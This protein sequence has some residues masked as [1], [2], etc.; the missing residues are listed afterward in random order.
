LKK[1][2]GLL[3]IAGLISLPLWSQTDG[4][5]E[6]E[7]EA[8]P[9]STKQIKALLPQQN[10]SVI[11][12][13]GED[14]VS[15]N[16][17]R[18]PI[19]NYSCSGYRTLQLNQVNPLHEGTSY[20]SDYVFYVEEDGIYELWYGGTPPGEKDELLPS[21]AS[22][23]RYILDGIYIEDIYRENVNVVEEYAPAY[24]WNY[25][26]NVTLS[27]GE[28]SLK[29]EIMQ[30]RSYDSRYFFYLD[31]FFLVKQEE[32]KRV[33]SGNLPEVFPKD[34]DNR[35]IDSS[36]LS[37]EEYDVLIRDNPENFENYV[38]VSK[39]YSLIGDYLNAL[40]Y[41]KKASYLEP[42]NP[43]IMLLTAKNMIW[44]GA[45]S[46]G[47]DLYKS[48]L[49]IVPERIDLWTEAGKIAGW[50]GQY[51]DSI[52]FFKG[53]LKNLPNDLSLMANLG[54][55]NLW[56]G[57]LNEAEKQFDKIALLTGD[58]L[59]L[60]RDLAEIFRTNGYADKAVPL[61]INMMKKYPQVLQLYMDLEQTYIENGQ[62]EKIPKLRELTEKTFIPDPEYNKIV[63][64]FYETQSLKEKV[65]SDY[66][67]QLRSDP[68]NLILRRTLAEIYFWNGYK[69]KAIAEYRNILSNYTYLNLLQT[70]IDM[71]SYLEL[72]D[73]NYALSNFI[74]SI[75]QYINTNQKD[76]ISDLKIYNKA[77]SDLE[78]MK[79]K[80]EAAAAKG[81]PVDSAAEEN[82]NNALI[83]IE[84]VLASAIYKNESFIEKYNSISTQFSA[85]TENLKRLLEDEIQSKESFKQLLDGVDWKWNREAM[86]EELSLVKDD[87]VLL[88]HFVLG[89]IAQ[90]EGRLKEAQVNFVTV[91]GTEKPLKGAPFA[92]YETEVWLG[93]NA[94]GSDTYEKYE[95]EIDQYCSYIYFLNDYLDYLNP[96]EDE[97]TF[98]Y[99][100]EDASISVNAILEQFKRIKGDS[101]VIHRE[102]NQ[103]INSIRE[104]LL[105]NMEQGFYRLSSDTYL[106][107]NELGDFY[108]NEKM[109]PEAISQYEQVLAVDPW[110]Q[111]AKFKLAQVYHLNGDWSKALSI[112]KEIYDGDPQYNNVAAF[113]NELT[114]DFA[115]SF[116]FSGKSFSDAST[117]TFDAQA[118]YMVHF[119]RT[120]AMT[121]DYNT[122]YSRI[123]L[124]T[125]D[126]TYLYQNLD[127]TLPVSLWS[128]TFTP[129]LGLY[130]NSDLVDDDGTDS[131]SDS[132]SV[133]D[134]INT[135]SIHG[136]GGGSVGFYQDPLNVLLGYLYDW[137]T[138]SFYPDRTP[139]SYH[140]VALGMSLNFAGTKVPFLE[141]T[142][143]TLSGS[144]RF[145]D[146]G[147]ISWDTVTELSNTVEIL[148]EPSFD[149][150]IALGFSFEDSMESSDNYY[151]PEESLKTGLTLGFTL[152]PEFKNEISLTERFWFGTDFYSSGYDDSY[153]LSFEIGNRLEYTKSDFTTY[154]NIT[155]S[156]DKQ[157]DPSDSGI[158]YWS[159]T[160]EVGVNALFPDYLKP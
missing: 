159:L 148:R 34:M 101:S 160:L 62:R 50:V 129:V 2:T 44:R 100:T 21:Y 123:T 4:N 97:E 9:V 138:D 143:W 109:Y 8:L 95:Q 102:I 126:A 32:G 141:D 52:S 75:P 111:S 18:E 73:R 156:F 68:D 86:M 114:R 108:Y 14:A 53:G 117:L 107:R 157:L 56:L 30:K 155:G 82:L 80:N 146:D 120:L 74:N 37:L 69:K 85:E 10:S 48:L 64:T 41:L 59:D 78:S 16:F 124:P 87:G 110:N 142:I 118:S 115:D 113:Y 147:N 130:V 51:Y 119:N 98:G 66:E 42:D 5:E 7:D 89:K 24:Y 19:L 77:V 152:A 93:E 83:E 149:L 76:L 127:L 135:Y 3:F 121:F 132:A 22:P 23:F 150:N 133:S 134:L 46:S 151:S 84:G 96:E 88:S 36:F 40:K 49:Q 154:L 11:F 20:N 28:H 47:L 90:Y 81:S 63:E 158:K 105:T 58:D 94:A 65:L 125:T 15:T 79:K 55:T 153:G 29:I 112:Y 33:L 131:Y 137:E 43:E 91:T 106:L 140:E 39:I 139:V 99:L 57:D 26:K 122:A 144:S 128:L 116:D 71:T 27:A 92:L 61:Y 45:T 17:N 145:L 54:I 70:E 6:T 25:I 12:I 35:T 72:I 104:T 13:E 103:N 67:E 31:N 60:N 1:I 38:Y 136:K